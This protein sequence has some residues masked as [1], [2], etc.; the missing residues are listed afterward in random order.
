MSH[1]P[2]ENWLFAD[3]PL[4][5][6][7]QRL[8]KSH[9]DECESCRSLS[10]ALDHVEASISSQIAPDPMLGF[11]E[12]WRDRLVVVRRQRRYQKTWLLTLAMFAIAGLILMSLLLLNLN[13]IN[14]NY[15][16]GQFIANFSRVVVRMNQLRNVFTSIT[17]AFP[18]LIPLLLILGMGGFSALTTLIIIWISSMLRLYKPVQKGV[19][20]S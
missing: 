14:W 12:R 1:Q 16:L 20:V 9:L 10:N 6:E 17:D 18:I 5:S 2:F 13:T 15:E 11:V 19:T 8:M 4:D 3:E 7:Q